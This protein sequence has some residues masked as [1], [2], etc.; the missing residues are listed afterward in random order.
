MATAQTYIEWIRRAIAEPGVSPHEVRDALVAGSTQ[1]LGGT[2]P[3]EHFAEVAAALMPELDARIAG[4]GPRSRP[5]VPPPI[6]RQRSRAQ[7]EALRAY[8]TALPAAA[9]PRPFHR[10]GRFA[11]GGLLSAGFAD[12]TEYVLVVSSSGRGVFDATSLARVGRDRGPVSDADVVP[13]IPPIA[14]VGVRQMSGYGTVALPRTTPDGW[15]LGVMS[16]D[17]DAAIW[18]S[19][20]RDDVE[21]PTVSGSVRIDQRFEE[22][23]AAGFSTSGQ[24]LVIAE[25]HTLHLFHRG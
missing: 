4:L 14:G 18:I 22:V 17:H 21:A 16:P 3:P 23:R 2:L 9:V 12:G 11:V 13:G 19:S 24:S 10:V 5:A 8:I 1:F 6:W 15:A 20:P 7:L 25:Q